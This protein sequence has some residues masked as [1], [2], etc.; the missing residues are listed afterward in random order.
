M[1]PNMS[2]IAASTSCEPMNG[3]M[4]VA[5]DAAAAWRH[6]AGTAPVYH[7]SKGHFMHLMLVASQS[8]KLVMP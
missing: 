2:W 6:K 8:H 1:P 7:E 4:W 5:G 3:E